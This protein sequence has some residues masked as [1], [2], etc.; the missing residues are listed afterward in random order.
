MITSSLD[1]SL[2]SRSSNSLLSVLPFTLSLLATAEATLGICLYSTATAALQRLPPP[3]V[4]SC[5][6]GRW[7]FPSFAG[8][9]PGVDQRPPILQSSGRSRITNV[10]H[11][12]R[13]RA[14]NPLKSRTPNPHRKSGR[15]TCNTGLL[16]MCC[17]DAVGTDIKLGDLLWPA[18][19]FGCYAC[20]LS[21]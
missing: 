2:D 19:L 3:Y 7:V 21:Y 12:D 20:R 4:P 11:T 10:D 9:D 1:P 8:L 15:S 14:S 17:Q 16:T 18:C 5:P 13:S 6:L